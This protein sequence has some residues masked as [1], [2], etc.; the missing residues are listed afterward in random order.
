MAELF[1]L[2]KYYN[3]PRYFLLNDVWNAVNPVLRIELNSTWW[4]MA[5]WFFESW[6]TYA[7]MRIMIYGIHGVTF[8]ICVTGWWF[9]T[10]WTF[11]IS[12][13]GCHPKPIDE[14]ILFKMVK[15]T[16]QVILLFECATNFWSFSKEIRVF[17]VMNP[18]IMLKVASTLW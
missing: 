7:K 17:S 16:N 15:S 8:T 11:S 12:Y 9:G 14:L 5:T 18:V 6:Q 1:R 13:M 2:V 4:Y 10:F 3:L